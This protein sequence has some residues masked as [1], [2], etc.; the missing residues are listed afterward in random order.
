MLLHLRDPVAGLEAARGVIRPGGQ[1]L[2]IE[3]Y[4]LK[5]SLLRPLTPTAQLGAH[6]TPFDWWLGNL[7]YLRRALLLAGFQSVRPRRLFRLD[8]LP[9]KRVPFVALTASV[10]HNTAER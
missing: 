8:V 1:L 7:A 4:D 6:R 3:P 9:A 10:S 5:G 2:V